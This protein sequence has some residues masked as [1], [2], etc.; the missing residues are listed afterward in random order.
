MLL[1]IIDNPTMG[2]MTN[3]LK[4]VLEYDGK[5]G[6]ESDSFDVETY[7]SPINDNFRKT[8]HWYFNEYL[9]GVS[10]GQDTSD[11]VGKLVKFG[12]YMGDELLGEDHQMLRFMERIDGL[13]YPNLKVQL[14]SKRIEFF[15]ELWEAT[16]LHEANYFLAGAAHSFSRQFT[17][18][19]FK[20]DFPELQ[21]NLNT[22]APEQDQVSKLLGSQEDSSAP[23][24]HNPLKVLY[25][26][27]RDLTS[28]ENNAS[29]AIKT[30]IEAVVAGGA[31]VLG[32]ELHADAGCLVALRALRRNPDDLAGDRQALLVFHQGQ[33]HEYLVAEVVALVGRDEQSTILDE[34]HVGRV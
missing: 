30:S 23:V 8:L 25:L 9:E 14:E 27:S 17:G 24:E 18:S 26:V 32:R 22:T 6:S 29:N 11:V 34:R 28:Q 5:A 15:S 10:H 12:R 31:I 2:A 33:Q 16:I 4:L 19:E 21:F 1:R 20:T 7:N 13:G 3:S